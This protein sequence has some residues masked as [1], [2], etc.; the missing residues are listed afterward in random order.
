MQFPRKKAINLPIVRSE[1]RKI[2]KNFMVCP[3]FPRTASGKSV[4]YLVSRQAFIFAL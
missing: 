2:E 1:K 3:L 4:M